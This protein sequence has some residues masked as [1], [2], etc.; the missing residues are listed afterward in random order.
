[1]SS[2]TNEWEFQ[3]DAL[4]WINSFLGSHNLGFERATQEFRNADGRR[5]DIIVWSDHAARKAVVA[6]ELKRPEIALST[7][8]RDAV[9]KAQKVGAPYVALWNMRRLDLHRTPTAPRKDLLPDD[10]IDTIDEIKTLATVDDW[11]KPAVRKQLEKLAQR[12]L[13]AVFDLTTQGVI[14]TQILDPTVFVDAL[15]ERVRELRHLIH[16]DFITGLAASRPLRNE[17]REWVRKQGLEAFLDDI[18]EALAAQRSYRLAGQ[19]LFYYALRRQ[20]TSLPELRLDEAKPISSQL[21]A[22]WDAVRVFDYEALYEESPLE[23]VPLSKGSEDAVRKLVLDLSHYDWNAVSV[24]VLGSIFEHMIPP[25]ERRILGQYYTPV[26]LV[27]LV[28]ALTIDTASDVVLDPGVG[29]GTFLY[30][31][32]DRIRAMS[33]SEHA[34]VLDQLWG[35][36]ISAFPAE[37]A[38]INLYRLD[39]ASTSNFPL[40]AVH[41]FFEL[42]PGQSLEFPPAKRNPGSTAKLEI[43][44]PIADAFVGNPPYVRSQQLDDLSRSYKDRLNT[45]AM[46][47]GVRRTAKFD[48]FAYW[49]LHAREFVREG[50][51]IGL[52][53]SGAWLNADYGAPLQ[54]FL[55]DYFQPVVILMSEAEVYFPSQDV[56]A[57]V[58]I[59]ERLT[60]SERAAPR[61]PMRFITLTTPL[62]KI[63]S[64]E[65][66][67][68][69]SRINS[70][71]ADLETRPEGVYEDFR[72]AVIDAEDERVALTNKPAE[73][74][75]WTL[76]LR[77][78]PLFREL[79]LQ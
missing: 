7:F 16:R 74:R 25:H 32:Y 71:A 41:D 27:D 44:L 21:R 75:A 54:K 68:Y 17:L 46:H 31:A 53:I 50:G 63:T 2:T 12:F 24:E 61:K 6:A 30:R 34:E 33:H 35:L 69:W 65:P 64:A 10:F 43:S 51:R 52:V 40:I 67:G 70:L 62:A 45:M 14:G 48:A 66:T 72:I 56:N 3:G 29:T 57:I 4:S 20:E 5:S 77:I 76:F 23:R 73:P 8:E 58:L 19:L 28:L 49:I 59:L 38:V 22:F 11:M 78:T 47:A 39:L 15:T 37:L 60:E 79:F 55:L 13:L 9:R 26:S 36:D 18:N 42:A 1:M